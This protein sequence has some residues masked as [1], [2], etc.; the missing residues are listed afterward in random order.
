[1][2]YSKS[3]WCGYAIGYYDGYWKHM[4]KFMAV[5]QSVQGGPI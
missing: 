1:M 4:D 3:V 2:G 5:K